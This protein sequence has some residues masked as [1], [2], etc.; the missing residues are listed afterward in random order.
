MRPAWSWQFDDERISQ[1]MALPA[2]I[3][4]EWAWEGSVGAGVRVAVLDSGIEAT[5]PLVGGI[6][7]SVSFSYDAGS[8]DLSSQLGDGE[9]LSGH[10][11]ACASIIRRLTGGVDLYSIRVLG[12]GL[13]GKVAVLAAGL[14]WAIEQEMDVVNLSLGTNRADFAGLLHELADVAYFRQMVLV[15][16]ASNLPMPSYPSHCASVISVASA[17][18][19]HPLAHRYNP[20]P[21]VE[22]GAPG[23]DIEVAWRDGRIVRASGNSFAAPH[24]TALAAR[25][26]GKHPQ[27]TPFQVKT[28]LHALSENA[29]R[30]DLSQTASG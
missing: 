25:I 16:A 14:R 1:V 2:P 12:A 30:Q 22:F 27:L 26:L 17:R 10:G 20:S 29:G 24:I 5:H 19:S 8:H 3:T 21:P 18:L 9:D 23:I 4:P 28:V 6:A 13:R 15:A 7:G 11:T